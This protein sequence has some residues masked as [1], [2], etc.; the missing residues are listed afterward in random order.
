[1]PE[2]CEVLFTAQYLLSKLKNHKITAI[3]ILSGR[4]THQNLVGKDLIEKLGPLTIR[5]IDTK[6]KFMWMKLKSKDK[7]YVYLMSTFGL[8]GEWSFDKSDN[9]RVEFIIKDDTKEYSL[10]YS[11]DRNF[12]TIQI[13]DNKDVLKK[14]LNLLG[15]DLLKSDYNLVQFTNRMKEISGKKKNLILIK[16]LMDQT[17]KGIGSGLGNYLTSNINYIAK[18]SP[19]RKISSLTD[20]EIK[21]LYN[22]IKYTLKLCYVS[23]KIGYMEKF[24][25]LVDERKKKILSGQL[26]NYLPE[27]DVGNKEFEFQVY[28]KKLDP[29]GNEVIADK[30]IGK[31]ST[32]WVPSVQK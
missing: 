27:I 1:M 10:Y 26:P 30:I 12:G 16:L 24:Q 25:D 4:Y 5:N 13:V 23:N 31:R 7:K 28:R 14:K 6:G 17:N 2:I 22:A 18:L 21:A 9:S 11:D 20:D 8:T 32:Y 15:M 3:N 19:H 29:L